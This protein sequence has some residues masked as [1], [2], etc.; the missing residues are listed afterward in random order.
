MTAARVATWATTGAVVIWAV[1]A[2]A[3]GTAGGL[4]RSPAESPL[5]LAG[6]LTFL[7][8][9]VAI[10]LAV[11]AGRGLAVRL[12]GVL[13]AVTGLFVAWMVIDTAIAALAPEQ[14]PHWVW[15][16]LQ[17]WVIAVLTAV[18]WQVWARREPATAP[19]AVG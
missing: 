8:G 16:E 7:V 2:V 10:G 1:K 11:T 13:G 4:D 18:G 5:F 19:A 15:E 12:L 3:I 6:M 9:V 17:L 14:D